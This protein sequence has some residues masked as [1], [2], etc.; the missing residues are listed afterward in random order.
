MIIG[1]IKK[2]INNSIINNTIVDA[3]LDASL[4]TRIESYWDLLPQE[5]ETYI[6]KILENAAASTIQK[7]WRNIYSKNIAFKYMAL[8][9]YYENMNNSVNVISKEASDIIEF[10]TNRITTCNRCNSRFWKKFIEDIL[11]SLQDEQYTGGPGAK[12]YN[13]IEENVDIIIYKF[14]YICFITL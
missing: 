6:Y 5:I 3:N 1:D 9:C 8:S 10:I 4:D 7:C 12:Y 11:L 2:H 13:K 14:R